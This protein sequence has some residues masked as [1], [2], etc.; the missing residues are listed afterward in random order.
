MTG[1]TLMAIALMVTTKIGLDRMK[2]NN[3][4]TL[5]VVPSYAIIDHW[6]EEIMYHAPGVFS[7][8]SLG[9]YSKLKGA[10]TVEWFKPFK[11]V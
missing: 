4:P 3:C 9:R 8:D 6:E 11:V 2:A 5:V 7:R 10:K 1:K